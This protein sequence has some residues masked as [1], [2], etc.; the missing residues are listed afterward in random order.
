MRRTI[1]GLAATA[2]TLSLAPA[3]FAQPAVGVVG[4]GANDA[5]V[6]FD[7]DAPSSVTS[8]RAVTGLLGDE[9]LAGIDY[10]WIPSA[11]NAATGGTPGLYALGISASGPTGHL[12]RIEI[13]TAIATPVNAASVLTFNPTATEYGFDFNPSADAIRITNNADQSFRVSPGTGA[14]VGTDT[15]LSPAFQQI[16]TA[17]YDRVDIAPTAPATASNTTLFVINPTT[18]QLAY[19]GGLNSNPS[20][21]GGVLTPIGVLGTNLDPTAAATF[22]IAYDGAA[23]ATARPA[24]GQPTFYRVDLTT[25]ALAPVSALAQDLEGLAV[26]PGTAQFLVSDFTQSERGNAVITVTR[27]GSVGRPA[28]VNYTTGGGSATPGADY[29]P[30]AGTLTFAAGE[31][32]RSFTVPIVND[33]VQEDDET[34]GLAIGGNGPGINL[35][36]TTQAQLTIIDND[37]PVVPQGPPATPAVPAPAADKTAPVITLSSLR[38]SYSL[39]AFKKGITIRVAT[40]EPTEVEAAVNARVLRATAARFRAGKYNLE[41]ASKTTEFDTT[42]TIKLRPKSSLIGK[43]KKSFKVRVKV[44]AADAAGNESTRT[45]VITIKK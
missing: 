30:T 22:D 24:G 20:P 26:I 8:S 31:A 32:R 12:Y 35:G 42:Q 6:T 29:T 23:F 1:I 18:N 5:L 43:P 14:V 17:A 38:S 45:K 15:N 34:V 19:Q 40:N 13:A 33:T 21:N 36:A 7:T 39:S 9:R 25:G 28:S 44:V 11:A 4:G 41:L 27:T 10:R 3:A 2:A 37:G 16:G